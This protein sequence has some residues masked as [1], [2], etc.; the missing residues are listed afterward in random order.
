MQELKLLAKNHL[1][2]NWRC[3]LTHNGKKWLLLYSA[4]M[5]NVSNAPSVKLMN[6]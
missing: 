2:L 6:N 1:A 3:Q 5:K 4:T